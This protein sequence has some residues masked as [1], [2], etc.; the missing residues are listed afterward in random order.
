MTELNQPDDGLSIF[1]NVETG[2]F[3]TRARGYDKDQV[4]RYVR[5]L[6]DALTEANAKAR[7]RGDRLANVEQHAEEL[8]GRLSGTQSEL[9]AARRQLQE[10]DSP[11][12]S[13]LG[14]HVE[15]LL[16]SSEQQ[17]GELLR[18]ATE[19]AERIQLE[20]QDAADKL[21]AD[22]EAWDQDLRAKTAAW[23]ENLRTE[24][25]TW[26]ADLRA[27]TTSWAEQ[28]RTEAAEDARV[29]KAQATEEARRLLAETTAAVAALRASAD[30]DASALREAVHRETDDTRA[31][32]MQ[33]S[34]EVRATAR[35]EAD[36]VRA[37]AERSATEVRTV[38]EQDANAMREGATEA[39]REARQ[40]IDHETA[41]IA[42]ALDGIQRLLGLAPSLV[43][44]SSS[45]VAEQEPEPGGQAA[46][47][48]SAPGEGHLG[49]D[50]DE[51]AVREAETVIVPTVARKAS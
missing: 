17:A 8:S 47:A 37:E 22:T 6:E 51:D 2:G 32:A 45:P 4:E 19:E 49:T 25:A 21:R 35:R 40:R 11:S 24:T 1:D 9:E 27:R 26:D 36:A 34:S 46:G 16:R 31:M 13:G 5:K 48:D 30:R 20:A 43:A 14:A 12:F 44:R 39:L 41:Q 23:D 29:T 50:A 15:A 3:H 7:D 33:E 10:I 18:R 38:A 28:L 42:S